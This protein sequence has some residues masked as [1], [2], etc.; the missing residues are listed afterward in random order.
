MHLQSIPMWTAAFFMAAG[1][2]CSVSAIGAPQDDD[3]PA[4]LE[5]GV[6]VTDYDTVSLNVQNTDLSQ[7]LQLL[8]IQAKRNI[9]PSPKVEGKVTANLYD[10]TFYEALDAILQQN[11]SG[12]KEKGDFI[13]I[14]TLE[15]LRQIE[16]AER[17]LAYRVVK[18]NYI[19]AS[20]ASTFVTPLL[21]SAGSIAISGN[22]S[23]GFQ[24]T[25]S[26]GGA[27]SYAHSDTMVVRDYQENIDE[28]LKIVETLD[29][30]PKQV[31]VEATI[32]KADVTENNAFGVDFSILTNLAVD[33]FANP[34]NAV[35]DL[36]NGTVQ[37][38][39]TTAAI[40]SGVGNVASGQGGLKVGVVTNNVAAFIRALDSVTDTTIVANPKLLALN[41]QKADVLIGEKIGYLSTTATATATTQTV[42]FLDTG[43]QLT[44]RPFVSDDGYVRLE[45]RPQISSARIRDVVP[46]TDTSAVTIPDEITQ[47]LTTNVMVRDGQTVVLG[48]LFKEETTIARD[49]IPL[50][51][52]V[53]IAGAAFKGKDDTM[54]RAEVIFLITPHIVRDK[55]LYAAGDSA[56]DGVE[57]AR[58]GA[59]EGLL[60]WSRSKMTAAHMRDALQA[61]ENNDSD[62][63]LY[64]VDLALGLD[65]QQIEVRRLKEKLTGQRA[66]WPGRSLMSDAV[67]LMVERA[68]E[69][70]RDDERARPTRPD[71][72]PSKPAS[73]DEPLT[74]KPPADGAAQAPAAEIAPVQVEA[75]PADAAPRDVAPVSVDLNSQSETTLLA[76]ERPQSEA[77]EQAE[78][79]D[80]P[81]TTERSAIEPA[82]AD[83]DGPDGKSAE[84]EP[85]SAAEA[86]GTEPSSDEAVAADPAQADPQQGGA[87]VEVLRNTIQS[88]DNPVDD[89]VADEG[90][91]DPHDDFDAW[92]GDDADAN[93][94]AQ[95]QPADGQDAPADATTS[96]DVDDAAQTK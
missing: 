39:D 84:A 7:V 22:V 38:A 52:D 64:E 55:A 20:D 33:A 85:A 53:P 77:T 25:L 37:P 78:A 63:A 76:E 35:T 65:S 6:S 4:T 13:Y 92:F 24:P 88:F 91:W 62:T 41:R 36:I 27:N 44:L 26:D 32:L 93:A 21:S 30:R 66:Y 51:G 95:A 2:V 56:K 14:Y 10:V 17:K 5:E 69:R 80:E 18:L 71:P 16:Q 73:D 59:R 82:A 45:L 90:D 75:Q 68:T 43:T 11:G 87:L 28:I 54:S 40:T 49:Q 74:G 94:E 1:S 86:D 67:D 31:L 34:L 58:I 57:M 9:V 47:E 81:V 29:T 83:A 79:T 46:G 60:P 42:E 8:S 23:V 70:R 15:E 19:T 61:L 50:L 3:R 48:G 89:A 72:R 12:Y 96:V